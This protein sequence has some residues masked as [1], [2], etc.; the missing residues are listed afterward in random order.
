MEVGG[1]GEH[2]RWVRGECSV[3]FFYDVSNL[4]DPF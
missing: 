2:G 1:E 4:E 3:T